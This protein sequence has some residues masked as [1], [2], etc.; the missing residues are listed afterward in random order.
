MNEKLDE[1]RE[2]LDSVDAEMM[3]LFEKRTELSARIGEI[4]R[5]AGLAL[6]DLSREEEVVKTRRELVPEGMREGAERLARLLIEESKRTQRRGFNLYLIGMPDSGKTRMARRLKEKLMLPVADTDKMI[7][8]RMGMDIETIF[9][10]FGEEGFRAME[11]SALAASAKAGGMIV[12]TGGGAPMRDENLRLMK[13]SGVIVFLDRALPRLL[14]QSTVNR[15]LLAGET[16]EEVNANIERLYYERRERYLSAADLTVD[17]DSGSALEEVIELFTEKT[18]RRVERAVRNVTIVSLSKGTIGE[19]FVKHELDIGV[20]RLE[21]MGLRVKFS[22][23]AL[24]GIDYLMEHPEKRAEDLLNALRDPSTDMILCAIGG[25]EGYR[26]APY[27]FDNDELKNAVS[28]KIFLGFSDTTAHHFM[29]RKAGL[30]TFYGQSFLADICELSPDMLPYTRK[31]FEELITTGAIK[32]IA[33]SPV[34]YASR[35]DFSPAAVGTEL[36]SH[37][38]GGFE[39]LQGAPRFEG[40]VL[41]GCIDSIYDMFYPDQNPDEPEI[42]EKYGLFPAPEEWQGKLLLI[43]TSEVKMSPEKFEKALLTL[44]AAGV[45]ANVSGILMGKPQ[46]EAYHEDYK[47]VLIE[48]VDDPELPILANISIGHASPRCIIPFGRRAKVDADK[49]E[50]VFE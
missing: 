33:P 42:I 34:W 23:H 44:K 32:R 1:I 16:Q 9:S 26:L 13:N 28:N 3:R 50:I 2:K 18:G 45:L 47:R 20:R 24:A 19:P 41:G 8:E 15:P 21:E 46:D 7:M 35:E 22:E 5:A 40:E 49:Q 48:A 11:T 36:P 14:G 31:Y 6:E 29:L 37:E 17:P 4:K 38:N 10:K 30:R 12:A 39:L 43:E 25:Y 27:L